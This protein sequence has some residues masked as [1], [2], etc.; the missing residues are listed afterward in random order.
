MT[1]RELL[2]QMLELL[3][4]ELPTGSYLELK[5]ALQARLAQPEQKPVADDIA[6][7]LACRNMLDAQP[8]PPRILMHQATPPAAQ[9]KPLTGDQ[10]EEIEMREKPLNGPKSMLNFARAIEAAHGITGENT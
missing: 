1:D 10:L 6:S 3:K 5:N 9:R 7:I 8:V 4:T 2:Q